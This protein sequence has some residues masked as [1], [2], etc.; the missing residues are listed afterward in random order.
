MLLSVGSGSGIAR[1]VGVEADE[2]VEIPSACDAPTETSS[3]VDS[4]VGRRGRGRTGLALV[5]VLLCGAAGA[6]MYVLR[7]RS[8]SEVQAAHAAADPPREPPA[9]SSAPVVPSARTVTLHIESN[10]GAHASIDGRDLG[11]TP[12]DA[13]IP[14]GDEPVRL[15]LRKEGYIPVV[16]ELVPNV[17]QRLRLTLNPAPHV[18]RYTR[19]RRAPP[20]TSAAPAAAASPAPTFR[21]W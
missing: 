13:V 18:L 20:P 16:E 17:D 8:S 2:T 4:R 6:S 1:V 19:P 11:E 14:A 5:G 15:E 21:R 7:A 3:V 10:E 12:M 9:P